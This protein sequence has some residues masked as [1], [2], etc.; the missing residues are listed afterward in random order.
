MG[1]VYVDMGKNKWGGGNGITM[2]DLAIRWAEC[3]MAL[4][5]LCPLAWFTAG[6]IVTPR[7]EWR[8]EG[9]RLVK[10][11]RNQFQRSSR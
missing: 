10:L 5:W 11:E 4:V 1:F 2:T 7:R 3:V 9:N 6:S 8:Q